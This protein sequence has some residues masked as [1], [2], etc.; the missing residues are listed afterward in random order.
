MKR[1][2][3]TGVG[4]VSPFGHGAEILRASAGEGKTAVRILSDWEETHGLIT[5][6]GAPVQELRERTIPRD[7]R[8]SMG[9]MGIFSVQASQEAV[10]DAGGIDQFEQGRLGCAV[11][12]TIGSTVSLSE[13]FQ[14]FFQHEDHDISHLTPTKFFHCISNSAAMNVANALGLTGCVQSTCGACAS[15]ILALGFGFDQIRLGRQDA[16][17]CGGA[18]ELSPVA[19]GMFDVLFA[20]ST[21]FNEQPECSPRPFDAQRDGLVC[22]E[23]AG[24]LLLESYDHALARGAKIYAEVLGFA[25]ATNGTHISQLNPDALEKTIREALAEAGVDPGEI[26]YVNA[27]ATGTKAG[28]C[29]E[30]EALRRVFADRVPVS[31][32]KGYLGH[33]LGASGALELILALEMMR[34]GTLLST[35]NLEHVGDDCAGLYHLQ[36]TETRT[37]RTILKNS[38]GFG[39]VNTALVIRALRAS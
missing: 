12:S 11:G 30:A 4:A 31:S 24:I 36:Q 34:T 22:G 27:H 3:I 8:R 14:S 35:R 32:L 10:A 38:F 23:G 29:S 21:H 25:N 1:V 7:L 17:L 39:G 18:E 19:V 15:S 28:D 37:V 26:D 20:T 6:L 2:V 9:R 13:L 33:T 16:V 5:R